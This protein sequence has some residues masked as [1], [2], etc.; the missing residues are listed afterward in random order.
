MLVTC[1]LRLEQFHRWI[2]IENE[3]RR[4]AQQQVKLLCAMHR[5]MHELE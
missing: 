4:A 5:L 3:R 1:T 2:Q